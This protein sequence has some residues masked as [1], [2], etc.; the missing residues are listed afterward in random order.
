MNA[1]F[2]IS[3]R[4]LFLKVNVREE[5]IGEEGRKVKE[6]EKKKARRVLLAKK[7]FHLSNGSVIV[8]IMRRYGMA[9]SLRDEYGNTVTVEWDLK[10]IFDLL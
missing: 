9:Y 10:N 5:L 8:P 6:A 1:P 4:K 7:V 3:L 2:F